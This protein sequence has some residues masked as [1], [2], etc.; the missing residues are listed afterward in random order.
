[1]AELVHM[2]KERDNKIS[3]INIS[4][5]QRELK[6]IIL[7]DGFEINLII[8][9]TV[10][11]LG[12]KW[13]PIAFN[14]R[15]VDNTTVVPKVI[16]RNVNFQVDGLDFS[17]CLVVLIMKSIESS[18]QMLLGRP[19]LREAKVKHDW[20]TGRISMKKGQEKKVY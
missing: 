13:E 10:M 12:L 11:Q 6:G 19:W 7:D 18:Y 15:M 17:I 14:V 3:K 9:D 2:P 5:N 4:I 20:Y 8:Q 1:M 16:I